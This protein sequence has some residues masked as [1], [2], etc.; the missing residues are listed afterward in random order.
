MAVTQMA[1]IVP[2]MMRR[3][4]DFSW[5]EEDSITNG[6]G[7]DWQEKERKKELIKYI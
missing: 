7:T 6:L 5:T 3:I 1:S 2:A 4:Q